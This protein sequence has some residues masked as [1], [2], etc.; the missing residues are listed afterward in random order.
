MEKHVITFSKRQLTNYP[1]YKIVSGREVMRYASVIDA[2]IENNLPP[3]EI[4]NSL[5]LGKNDS[6]GAAPF[7]ASFYLSPS[8]P[9]PVKMFN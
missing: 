5:E 1:I 2:I 4:L 8:F 7:T 6:N 3:T 9:H